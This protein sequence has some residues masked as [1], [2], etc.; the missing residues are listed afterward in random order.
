VKPKADKSEGKF[1]SKSGKSNATENSPLSSPF[2]KAG[3]VSTKAGKA[4]SDEGAGVFVKS[5]KETLNEIMSMSHS[6]LSAKYK[7][8][9]KAFTNERKAS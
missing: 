9:K 3:K 1:V 4:I 8:F 5:G 7:L 6:E 2:N